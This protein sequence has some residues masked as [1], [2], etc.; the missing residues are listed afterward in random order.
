MFDECILNY[1][2]TFQNKLME[3]IKNTKV[4]MKANK[5]SYTHMFFL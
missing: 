5:K 4:I 3:T 2:Q 1:V